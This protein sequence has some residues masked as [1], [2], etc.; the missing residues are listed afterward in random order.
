MLFE[1][2]SGGRKYERLSIR[3]KAEVRFGDGSRY[4]VMTRNLSFGGAFV[5]GACLDARENDACIFHLLPHPEQGGGNIR[6]RAR[7]VHSQSDGGSAVQFVASSV[8][9]YRRF[10]QMML[11]H[12]PEPAYLRDEL[13]LAPGWLREVG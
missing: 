13:A 9:D 4:R 3:V 6:L 1:K 11:A 8:D 2:S 5:T 7:I 10:M 12:S